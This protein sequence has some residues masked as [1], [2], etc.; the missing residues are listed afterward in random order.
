[1]INKPNLNLILTS[2]D[3]SRKGVT[4]PRCQHICNVSTLRTANTSHSDVLW[5]CIRFTWHLDPSIRY[6]RVHSWQKWASRDV[7]SGQSSQ[8]WDTL[9]SCLNSIKCSSVLYFHYTETWG[10]NDPRWA[11]RLPTTRFKLT[12]ILRIHFG[13]KGDRI[14]VQIVDVGQH[15]SCSYSE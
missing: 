7:F 11:N 12:P 6:T 3:G 9:I 2:M 4:F 15:S 10:A 8:P 5:Q 1:M 13:W 14:E